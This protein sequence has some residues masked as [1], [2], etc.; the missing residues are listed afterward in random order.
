MF[1][2]DLKKYNFLLK[3]LIIKDIKLKYRNSVLGIL[4]TLLEPLL[5]MLILIIVFQEM[6]GRET[7]NYP[8][9]V[10]SGRLLYGFYSSCSRRALKSIRANGSMI[11]KIYVPRYIYPLS[12][13]FSG[14]ITFLISLII[15]AIVA[16]V[17]KVFP[18]VYLLGAILPLA[19][20]LILAIGTGLILSTLDVFFRDLEYL[21]GVFL[22]MLMYI[23]AIF[24][25]ESRLLDAAAAWKGWILKLNPLY[26]IIANFRNAIFGRPLELYY[27]LYAL[28]FSVVLLIAG[29][30]VFYKKQDK[31]IL[32]V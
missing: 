29:M 19:T 31:F 17:Q 11:R 23:S 1:F 9:Y 8:V 32:Y 25:E 26:G 21:W 22:T 18:T 2:R 28:G 5:T 16:L 10:L 27:A 6:F 4:W 20:L 24:Y 12:C 7:V 30:I 14:F 3:E 13:V 15:L